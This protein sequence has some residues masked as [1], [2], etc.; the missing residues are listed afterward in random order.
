MVFNEL[1][2]NIGLALVGS[3]KKVP[4]EIGKEVYNCT[5]GEEWLQKR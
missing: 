4:R 5:L 3:L 1:W 2:Y